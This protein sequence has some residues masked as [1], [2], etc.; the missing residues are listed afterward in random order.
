MQ[1]KLTRR[2]ALLWLA[3]LPA[4]AGPGRPGGPL[5]VK[6]RNGPPLEVQKL[7]GKVVLL[8]FM[9]TVCPTCKLAAAGIEKLYRELGP[10]GFSPVA[11]ALNVES[12]EALDPYRREHGLTF[13]LGV[14]SR[15]VVG[16]YLQHPANQPFMVPT[17]VLLDRQGRICS[18]EVGWNGDAALRSAVLPL[19]E[20]RK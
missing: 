5:Q 15:E 2:G 10:R 14:T 12:P 20:S 19:L 4:A 11:V 3:A 18:V 9:T 6:V 17:L 16:S 7:K 8:D 13:P 1:Y